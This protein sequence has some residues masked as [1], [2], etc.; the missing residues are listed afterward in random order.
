[1]LVENERTVLA[2]C[3]NIVDMMWMIRNKRVEASVSD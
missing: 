3:E 2:G 1:V